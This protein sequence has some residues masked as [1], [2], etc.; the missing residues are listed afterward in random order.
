MKLNWAERLAVNNPIRVMEQRIEISWM[1]RSMP[2]DP[3]GM[4]LE[5]GCGRGAAAG[6]L[7]DAFQPGFLC[8]MD[9]D[10]RM[11]RMAGR[12]LSAEKRSRIPMYVGDA[13]QL[14]HPDETFDAVFGFG[15]LH[16]VPEWRKALSELARVLKK[17]GM[18]FIEELYP[19]LYQNFVTKHILLHPTENRFRSQDLREAL[20]EAGLKVVNA[21]EIRALG[22]LAVVKKKH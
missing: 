1:K 15:V 4:M 3:G 2:H 9:L 18:Y 16:H 21:L 5:V 20:E 22:I 7:L 12:Y 17:G 8:T 13:A 6:I 14:P 19:T 10:I 11:I